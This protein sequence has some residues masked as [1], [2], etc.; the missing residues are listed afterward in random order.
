MESSVVQPVSV[1]LAMHAGDVNG[2]C[3]L[4]LR[5]IGFI[6]SDP[7]MVLYRRKELK[8]LFLSD[9]ACD[10][11]GCRQ[12]RIYGRSRYQ[13]K[14]GIREKAVSVSEQNCIS[15]PVNTVVI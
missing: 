3:Y 8:S 13:R 4:R 6:E 7:W 15:I 12:G 14:K 10:R 11:L 1:F 5:T 2:N 9:L